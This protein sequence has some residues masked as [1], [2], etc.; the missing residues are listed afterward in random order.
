MG[1]QRHSTISK[2]FY[3]RWRGN[4]DDAYCRPLVPAHAHPQMCTQTHVCMHV[5]SSFQEKNTLNNKQFLRF[6]FLQ[7]CWLVLEA[8]ES[9]VTSHTP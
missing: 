2:H 7:M 5:C 1:T 9:D 8:S 4:K 6:D 3:M